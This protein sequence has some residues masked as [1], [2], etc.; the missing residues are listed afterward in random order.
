MRGHWIVLA[1]GGSLWA[2]PAG[3]RGGA[4]S[5]SAECRLYS[6]E[7]NPGALEQ[8]KALRRAGEHRAA[9]LVREMVETPRAI[10]LV[11]GTPSEVQE[12][13]R[14]E[15]RRAARQREV[16]VFVAYDIPM[17]D[18]GQ[19]S[20]GGAG[21][22]EE[23][24]AWIDAL[25]MAIGDR[26]AIV[27]LE[28]DSLGI[29]PHHV[30]LYGQL[31]WCQPA[32][33][34]PATAAEERYQQLNAAVDRL[35]Q[36]PNV[37]VYLDGTHSRWLP[38]GDAAWRLVR[39]GVQRAS[40]FFLNV[41]NYEPTE[42]LEK[43]GTWIASCIAFANNPEEGG[44]RLG[45]YEWCGSQYG[46]ANVEDFSTWVYTDEWY[47]ALLGSATPSTHF[48]IDTSRNGQG[49]WAPPVDAPPG[50]PQVWC[51]PPERGLGLRPT[52][53]TGSELVDAYLWVKV[54]GESDGACHR[55]EP[56]GSA[57]PTRGI[58]NPPAGAWFPEQVLELIEHA[59]PPLQ[60]RRD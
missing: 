46:P 24:L 41:S 54:P 59:N 9:R 53:D 36:Q 48:V 23:Y 19:F 37:R 8:M 1:V 33:A 56:P 3:A 58:V 29:I 42:Q 17:R 52:C 35:M 14:S 38:V 45:H 34:D 13:V 15:A 50:D 43:Y 44:W 20:S 51:N 11:G 4:E 10:W 22:A 40:G 57:D 26:R 32:Y 30:S 27:L 60:G 55:W 2:L 16:P 5:C 18:C 49:A 28:P 6:P 47:A 39:A 31:E 12:Q 25:A 21:S 7:P